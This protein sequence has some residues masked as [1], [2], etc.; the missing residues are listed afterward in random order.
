MR[1]DD[2]VDKCH[3]CIHRIRN[4][5]EPYCVVSC[6]AKARIVGDKNDPNS[7]VSKLIAK[8]KPM[9]L[10]NNKGEFLKDEEI[11]KSTKP[12]MYYIRSYSARKA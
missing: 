4:N 7:E 2:G 11:E 9:R 6:P 5:E 10:K 8:Y 1:S 12:N 3:F